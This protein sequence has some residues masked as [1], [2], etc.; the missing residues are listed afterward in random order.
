MIA[1]PIARAC[2]APLRDRP[3]LIAAEIDIIAETKCLP[4]FLVA[5]SLWRD[6]QY[7]GHIDQPRLPLTG[8]AR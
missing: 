8:A 6:N 1:Q 2:E 5:R 4:R 7:P 3:S